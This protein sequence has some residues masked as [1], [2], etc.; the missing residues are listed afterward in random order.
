MEQKKEGL[1]SHTRTI[2][3][4]LI[5]ASIAGLG[6]FV[7]GAISDI[8]ILKQKETTGEAR[9][10]DQY[11]EINKQKDFDLELVEWQRDQAETKAAFYKNRYYDILEE[12]LD[13]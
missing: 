13:R 3:V 6:G 4:S 9:D 1:D 10:T 12:G 8:S 5:F 2:L 11:K 7:A